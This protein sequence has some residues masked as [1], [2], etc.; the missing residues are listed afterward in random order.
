LPDFLKCFE[1]KCDA[2]DLGIGAV[3]HQNK[4]LIAFFSEKFLGP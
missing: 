1:V 4:H 2:S 3:L